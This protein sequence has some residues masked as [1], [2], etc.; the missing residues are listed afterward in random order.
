MPHAKRS[1][2]HGEYP[3]A[4]SEFDGLGCDLT[5]NTPKKSMHALKGIRVWVQSVEVAPHT[6]THTHTHYPEEVVSPSPSPVSRRRSGVFH[7]P[8]ACRP[9][10]RT[11]SPS[12]SRPK[13][14][15]PTIRRQ[16]P[17]GWWF[18]LQKASSRC[19][20]ETDERVAKKCGPGLGWNG[21]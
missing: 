5:K 16:Q 12:S 6:H 21:V 11:C 19:S 1:H 20:A 18:R 2:T 13:C 9:L 8:T 17:R 7:L 14:Q 4:M 3:V 15:R 10:C